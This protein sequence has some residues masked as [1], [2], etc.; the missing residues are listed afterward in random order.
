MPQFH[1]PCHPGVLFHRPDTVE[2]ERESKS[3]F[4]V[5]SRKKNKVEDAKELEIIPDVKD[6]LDLPL[7]TPMADSGS[8]ALSPISPQKDGARYSSAAAEK[9]AEPV[10]VKAN[11]V[12][13]EWEDSESSEYEKMLER[14]RTLHKNETQEVRAPTQRKKKAF[15]IRF[16]RRKKRI[17]SRFQTRRE[18]AE[19]VKTE[20]AQVG[21]QWVDQK[22]VSNKTLNLQKD[23]FTISKWA[24]D[25]SI[26]LLFLFSFTY[27][28]FTSSGYGEFVAYQNSWRNMLQSRAMRIKTPE[29]SI[30]IIE[31]IVLEDLVAGRR[32]YFDGYDAPGG[33]GEAGQVLLGSIMVGDIRL[34]QQRVIAKPCT[35]VGKMLQN[36]GMVKSNECYPPYTKLT[37][38]KLY[39]KEENFREEFYDDE[40]NYPYFT[41][42]SPFETAFGET[43]GDFGLY[44][45]GGFVVSFDLKNASNTL[46]V[47]KELQW[48]DK[49]TRVFFMDFSFYNDDLG[50]FISCKIVVEFVSS[51]APVV[52]VDASGISPMRFGRGSSN[53]VTRLAMMV[54]C[55]VLVIYYVIEELDKCRDS[56]VDHF[57]SIS[58]AW[59]DLSNLAL[60]VLSGCL[61]GYNLVAY[62]IAIPDDI[63]G[64]DLLDRIKALGQSQYLNDKIQGLNGFFLWFKLFKHV[65]VTRRIMVMGRVL[66]DCLPDIITFVFFFFIVLVAF[67]VLGYLFCGNQLQTFS[68]IEFS[69]LSILRSMYGDFDFDALVEVSGITGFIYLG[70]LTYV[71]CVCVC[72]VLCA[73]VCMCASSRAC[74]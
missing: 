22:W 35:K 26:Y 20:G 74:V 42:K 34:R 32:T 45:A 10:R 15:A 61:T 43:K 47:L 8:P 53:E 14:M 37:E 36:F 52:T 58:W 25:L 38:E 21:G 54:L 62:E 27:I 70:V 49:K 13:A 44:D 66:A 48:I 11:L 23:Q 67:S 1:A 4:S 2:P 59:L 40:E 6:D 65:T 50:L 63:P 28:I 72:A 5:F 19:F 17:A 51:Q 46:S 33:K 60:F 57:K 56:G 18:L 41:Y 9:N 71:V 39:T 24:K 12:N 55:F 68:S 64:N 16:E 31:Q 7:G 29:S 30:F 73:C 69:M 3:V